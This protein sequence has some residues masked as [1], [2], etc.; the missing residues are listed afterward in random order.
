MVRVVRI[1][2]V[3]GFFV[4]ALGFAAVFFLTQQTWFGLASFYWPTATGTNSHSAV[5]GEY[6]SDDERSETL[7]YSAETHYRCRVGDREYQGEQVSFAGVS[8]DSWGSAARSITRRYPRGRSV[9]V[10][11]DP[12]NPERAVLEPGIGVGVRLLVA[13]LIVWG[14]AWGFLSDRIRRRRLRKSE[15]LGPNLE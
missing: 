7:M 9:F 3:L 1:R 8:S 2:I 12:R 14:L 10:R 13:N 4:A 5:V 15:T 6:D 11:Y